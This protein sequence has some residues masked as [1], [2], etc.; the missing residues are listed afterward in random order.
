MV[1]CSGVERAIQY[2]HAIREYLTE[3]KSPHLAIVTFSG[4][5]E[6]GG[7]WFS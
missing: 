7:R 2:Y 6:Y 4:E 5:H 3:C 1:V